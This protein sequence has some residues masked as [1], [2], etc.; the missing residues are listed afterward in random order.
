MSIPREHSLDYPRLGGTLILSAGVALFGCW[1]TGMYAITGIAWLGAVVAIVALVAAVVGVVLLFSRRRTAEPHTGERMLGR[2][3]RVV[4][5]VAASAALL[6]VV[7]LGFLDGYVWMPEALMPG[8]TAAEIRARMDDAGELGSSLTMLGIWTVCWGLA[9]L[10]PCVL[11]VI[12]PAWLSA[13][14]M[15]LLTLGIVAAAIFFQWMGTFS[16][17]MGVADTFGTSGGQSS[18]WVFYS[19]LGQASLIAVIALWLRPWTGGPRAA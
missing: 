19:M 17:G 15:L 16:M 13:R 7:A 18:F 10:A 8:M 14:R 5:G 12:G 1:F 2:G 6:V 11:G 9:A 4:L 3:Q